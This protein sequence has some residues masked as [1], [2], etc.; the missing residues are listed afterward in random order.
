MLVIST[1]MMTQWARRPWIS[2]LG[3]LPLLETQCLLTRILTLHPGLPKGWGLSGH[4]LV[5]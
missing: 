1:P 2:V 4:S 3:I 5:T